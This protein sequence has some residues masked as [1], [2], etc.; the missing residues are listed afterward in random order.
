MT[1]DANRRFPA[2]ACTVIAAACL[3]VAA[4]WR[5]TGVGLSTSFA[6]F[7]ALMLMSESLVVALPMGNMSLTHPLSVAAAVLLGP[8][9]AALLMS[10]SQV[11]SLFG[12]R[13]ISA[14]KFL[15]NASQLALAGLAAGWLYLAAG[16]QLLSQGALDAQD[17]PRMI[18][19]VAVVAVAGMVCNFA[20]AGMAVH[21]MYG[22]SLRRIWSSEFAAVV[23]TEIA[24]GL[25]GVT[26]AQVIA[27]VGVLGLLL[28]VVPLGVAR[29]TY[30][31]YAELTRTYADTVRSLVAAIEAKDT[32]T[33]GHSV[34]V[35]EYAVAIAHEMGESEHAIERLE[36]AALLHDLGKVGIKRSLL[37]KPWSLSQ[38]E[39]DE[40][41]RHP[42]IGAHILE[43]V[44][45]LED[46]VPVIQS[47]HERV[48]GTGYGEGLRGDAIPL[49]ARILA[50][51]DTF[52]A[53][54]SQRPYRS[55]MPRSEALREIAAGAGS[56]FDPKTVDAF[57]AVME[58]AGDRAIGS[59]LVVEPGA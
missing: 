1:G 21:L 33:Q 53:M 7:A 20:L 57:L 27:A 38:E 16:G 10:L 26:M 56:Q 15:F 49:Q 29:S 35:A 48:D 37:S 41:R 23:P 40:V 22:V 19:P 24:L 14:V 17:F 3:C 11:P 52:D 32:Y 44:H 39:S 30:H 58:P 50:V 47:H 18:L 46:I 2:Y 6:L 43:S 9:H 45:Y 5:A 42:E 34:R 59:S 28:F 36:Y 25:V 55:A 8:T 31:R 13:R 51:A 12:E 4:S 54:T